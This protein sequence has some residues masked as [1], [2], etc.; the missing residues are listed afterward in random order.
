MSLPF[1]PGDA[2][3]VLQV[4]IFFLLVIGLPFVKWIGSKKNFVIHG[5]LTFLALIFHTVLVF[6]AMVPSLGGGF[7]GFAGFSFPSAL[8]FWSH[9]ILGTVAI[10]LGF[11]VVGVWIT[12]PFANMACLRMRKVMLPLLMVWLVSLVLGALVHILKIV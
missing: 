3:L 5:R 11:A 12:K 10:I 1:D 4:V 6:A 9:V 8:I 2:S 7:G